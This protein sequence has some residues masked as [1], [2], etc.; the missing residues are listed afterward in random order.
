MEVDPYRLGCLVGRRH[1]RS[2]VSRRGRN[3]ITK[4]SSFPDI[5]LSWFVWRG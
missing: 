4:V 5:L 3:Q 1:W 2:T